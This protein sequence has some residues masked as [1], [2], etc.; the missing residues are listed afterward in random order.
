MALTLLMKLNLPKEVREKIIEFTHD[1]RCW[2][3]DE[4]KALLC[5]VNNAYD[6]RCLDCHNFLQDEMQPCLVDGKRNGV[7]CRY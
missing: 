3:C 2:I 1:R 6:M 5:R 7:N 4:G